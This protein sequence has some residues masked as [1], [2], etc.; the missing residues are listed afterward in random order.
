MRRLALRFVERG[1]TDRRSAPGVDLVQ[2][3][4]RTG[5][6]DD[7][8]VRIPGTAAAGQYIGESLRRSAGRVDPPQFAEAEE[9]DV[10]VIGRPER[11]VSIFR[12]GERLRGERIKR[13]NP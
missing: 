1:E 7:D 13:P 12:S 6:E 11:M 3:V 8:V 2:R 4:R 9:A 10:A 5:G